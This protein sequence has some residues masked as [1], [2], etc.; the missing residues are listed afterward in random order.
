MCVCVC[1]RT[2][3]FR[4]INVRMVVGFDED[5]MVYKTQKID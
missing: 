1:A 3:L 2:C 5:D 4:S